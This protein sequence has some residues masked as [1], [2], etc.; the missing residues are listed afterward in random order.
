[1]AK[2]TIPKSLLA[3]LIVPSLL[4][5]CQTGEN[6]VN[7]NGTKLTTIQS[8]SAGSQNPLP[9]EVTQL[10]N[11]FSEFKLALDGLL[12]QLQK[13][14]NN[15]IDKKAV[16]SNATL[17]KLQKLSL[18]NNNFRKTIPTSDVNNSNLKNIDN[19]IQDILKVIQPLKSGLDLKAVK[20]IQETLGIDKKPEVSRNKGSFGKI[21]QGVI[22]EY[23]T[24]KSEDLNNQIQQLQTVNTNTDTKPIENIP[25]N[26]RNLGV[27]NQNSQKS[28]SGLLALSLVSFVAGII[29]GAI[30]MFVYKDRYANPKQERSQDKENLAHNKQVHSYPEESLSPQISMQQYT[31]HPQ[32]KG[33]EIT[34]L[35][36]SEEV[37]TPDSH[38][39]PRIAN[40]NFNSPESIL[41]GAYNK[42]RNS[43]LKIAIEVS[44]TEESINQ[45]RVGS[46]RAAILEKV[47][48][49]KGNYWIVSEQGIDYLLPKGNIKINEYNYETV[50]ALFDCHSYRPGYSSD[51]QLVR[52]ARVSA[53]NQKIWELADYGVLEF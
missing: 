4:I 49:G 36:F 42:N 16:N 8:N 25:N 48:K 19:T 53:I 27:E 28:S 9:A 22:Q 39:Q 17:E 14:V 32:T 44:E 23:L 34:P 30:A 26:N 35:K 20:Q 21:T 41:V 13:V 24:K 37:Y 18:A 47:G 38:N 33:T 6:H 3:L 11:T 12:T 43:L 46:D 1:M 31:S 45:R 52:P 51:F 29:I 50:E 2:R 15:K 40:E 10:R 5:G 7:E